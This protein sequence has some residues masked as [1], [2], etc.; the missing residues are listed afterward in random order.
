M[1]TTPPAMAAAYENTGFD[2]VTPQ[3][4]FYWTVK[5]FDFDPESDLGKVRVCVRVCVHS[6][7]TTSTTFTRRVSTTVQDLAA[8]ADKYG[9]APEL[10]LRIKFPATFPT[11]PP[12]IR[13]ERPMLVSFTGVRTAHCLHHR[14]T[15]APLFSHIHN[16]RAVVLV[17]GKQGVTNG[18]FFTPMLYGK[19]KGLSLQHVIRKYVVGAL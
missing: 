12:L 14:F 1:L 19:W 10:E 15:E 8:Y 16:T 2:V 18:A 4:P 7:P 13:L 5:L 9:V 6:H 3:N 17:C 11:D